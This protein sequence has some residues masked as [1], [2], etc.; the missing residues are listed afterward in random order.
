MFT[1]F[2]K[3]QYMSQV[4]PTAVKLETWIS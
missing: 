1:S 3:T 2:F 4:A